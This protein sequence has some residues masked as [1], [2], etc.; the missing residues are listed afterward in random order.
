MISRAQFV[1]AAFVA[2]AAVA[3]TVL[4]ASRSW[5]ELGTSQ[6]HLTPAE[7]ADAAAVHEH[8]PVALFDRLRARLHPGDRWWLEVPAGAADAFSNRGSVYRAYAV[9]WFLPALPADSR[10]DAT[11]VFRIANPK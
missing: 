9:F 4:G 3:A 11:V 7:A 5:G 10:S 6:P 8:L 2:A 1:L